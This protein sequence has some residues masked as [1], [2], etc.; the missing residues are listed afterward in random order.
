MYFDAS[1]KFSVV[2][3]FVIKIP[4]IARCK[5]TRELGITLAALATLLSSVFISS[6]FACLKFRRTV[7]VPSEFSPKPLPKSASALDESLFG[8][9]RE[10]VKC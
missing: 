9:V 8:T 3:I 10:V 6:G 7:K 4:P 1:F 2:E 5:E